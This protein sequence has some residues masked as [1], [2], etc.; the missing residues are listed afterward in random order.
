MHTKKS[1]KVLMFGS[2]HRLRR[3]RGLT[4]ALEIFLSPE[5]RQA[6]D[7][8]CD[9]HLPVDTIGCIYRNHLPADL[10][11]VVIPGDRIAFVP[12]SIP[13]PHKGLNPWPKHTGN[14]A[15]SKSTRTVPAT[16]M[17]HVLI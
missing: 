8:A 5:G 12:K 1:T 17:S 3:E 6:R 16:E 9:L 11:Q 14:P 13:G 4:P 15:G 7:I 2:L 10:D